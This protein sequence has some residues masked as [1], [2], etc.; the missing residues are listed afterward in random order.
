MPLTQ[1]LKTYLQR[2]GHH[3]HHSRVVFQQ[4]FLFLKTNVVLQFTINRLE[5]YL[6]LSTHLGFLKTIKLLVILFI[7]KL[8]SRNN[9]FKQKNLNLQ[10]LHF[11]NIFVELG[12]PRKPHYAYCLQER[13]QI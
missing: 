8:H 12:V 9:I 3:V 5:V 6:A 4:L 11:A 10:Y 2:W 13:K 7:I 1:I